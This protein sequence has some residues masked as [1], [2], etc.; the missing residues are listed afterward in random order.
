MRPSWMCTSRKTV[1]AKT[2]K[3]VQITTTYGKPVEGSA[4]VPRNQYV[5]IRQEKPKNKFQQD[6]PEYKTC[7]FI[8][9]AIVADV[10]G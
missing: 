10:D 2:G 8:T 6:A 4:I 3:L 9:E 7:K 1:A 5:E